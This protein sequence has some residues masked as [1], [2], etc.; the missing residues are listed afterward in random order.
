MQKLVFS[1]GTILIL[2]IVAF[3][4]PWASRAK[5][6]AA[7]NQSAAVNPAE[8]THAA[9]QPAAPDAKAPGVADVNPSTYLIGPQDM[10][11]VNVWKEP[12]VSQ[13]LPV[14]PDGMISLP[15]IGDVRAAGLT[16]VQLEEA[17]T[18]PLKKYMSEPQVT[19]IVTEVRSK[20]FNIV[21]QV[22]KPGYY[23]LDRQL[24]VLDAIALAGGFKDFAKTKKIYVLRSDASGKQERLAFNYKDVIKGQ[25][26][27]ENIELQPRDTIVVP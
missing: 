4:G 21:G 8:S 20:T 3:M 26:T 10:L 22:V 9:A 6:Q 2:T 11:T 23:P 16:P 5:A 18:A 1:P 17:I 19:V 7:A 27:Q 13:K 25:N 15:L 24:T 12:E 14:R